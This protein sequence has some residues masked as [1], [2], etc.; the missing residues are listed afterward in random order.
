MEKTMAT[1]TPK[2]A[3]KEVTIE[4][5]EAP[6]PAVKKAPAGPV[7]YKTVADQTGRLLVA[8]FRPRMPQI[9]GPCYYKVPA[10]D[11]AAFERTREFQGGIVVRDE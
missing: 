9:P 8:G 2:A 10:D 11:V 3:A 4:K 5:V 6:K 1:K 7:T